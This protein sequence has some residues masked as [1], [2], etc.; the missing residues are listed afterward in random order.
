MADRGGQTRGFPGLV[1]LAAARRTLAQV[2][3]RIPVASPVDLPGLAVLGQSVDA[4]VQF[5]V[6]VQVQVQV[7]DLDPDRIAIGPQTG[8]R[9]R[10]TRA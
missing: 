9:S 10:S 4:R 8:R 6:Q 2:I 3:A 1:V 5:Q 7:Q